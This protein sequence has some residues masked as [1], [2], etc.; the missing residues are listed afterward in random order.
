MM[1][2]G[3]FGE[4]DFADEFGFEPGAASHFGGGEAATEAPGLF[5]KIGERAIAAFYFLKFFVK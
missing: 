3:P 5:R 4:A 1:V 2:A